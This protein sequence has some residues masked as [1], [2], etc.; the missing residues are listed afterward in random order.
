MVAKTTHGNSFKGLLYYCLNEKKNAVILDAKQ[1]ANGLL[2]EFEAIRQENI[3]ITKPVWH[4]S[5]SFSKDDNI[6]IE[7][8]K[9][10]ANKLIN[11]VGFTPEN[12]QFVIIQHKDK[13]H[14]HCHIIANR[15]GFDGTAVND[16]Y[17]KSRVVKATKQL[18]N[19]Y[20][21]TKVQDI[22]RKRLLQFEN[23]NQDE[24]GKEY[25]KTAIDNTFNQYELKN[26]QDLAD[27]LKLKSVEMQVLKH[28]ITGKEY[29]ITFKTNN[30]LVKGSELGKKYAFKALSNR[31][32]PAFNIITEVV[33]KGIK[34][35]I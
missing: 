23:T 27:K 29:G 21:L 5:L 8:M 16:Y 1:D 26:I 22:S 33:S 30:M 4:T 13:D 3:N 28:A 15:V 12:H 32:H 35:R 17:S 34:I 7:Q 10:I 24:P 2:K 11:K 14:M 9:E 19:E 25:I 6:N 18:E 31:F 20:Q